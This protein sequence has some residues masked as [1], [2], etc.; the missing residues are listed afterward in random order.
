M[1]AYTLCAAAPLTGPADVTGR[2]VLRAQET[3]KPSLFCIEPNGM[4][5]KL[6]LARSLASFPGGE[7]HDE[8]D[9]DFELEISWICPASKY[10]VL[11]VI[12]YLSL[13]L[14]CAGQGGPVGSYVTED[15]ITMA[16][17]AAAKAAT[18]CVVGSSMTIDEATT[19]DE[20]TSLVSAKLP[21]AMIGAAAPLAPCPKVAMLLPP[22]QEQKHPCHS[23]PSLAV[24]PLALEW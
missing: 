22:V 24:P 4:V 14:P 18:A 23:L 3:K 5:Y 15:D 6:D 17:D 21:T 7:V 8:K 2:R 1:H 12:L 9:K 11:R 20:L 10:E 16:N 13:C 19:P